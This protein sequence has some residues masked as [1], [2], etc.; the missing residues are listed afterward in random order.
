VSDSPASPRGGDAEKTWALD[1]AKSADK[2]IGRL[3]PP[4]QKRVI[5]A[6]EKLTT[7]PHSGALRKLKNRPEHKLRVGDWRAIVE[8]DTTTKTIAIIRILPRGRA[9]DR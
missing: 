6:L 1:Y 7:D 9:Y 8:L 5:E 2:D 4:I 3:D